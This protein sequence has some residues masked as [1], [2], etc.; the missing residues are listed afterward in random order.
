M[1][2]RS[3]LTEWYAFEDGLRR[4]AQNTR[5]HQRRFTEQLGT[6]FMRLIREQIQLQNIT[7]TGTYENSLVLEKT[8]IG[9]MTATVLTFRPVGP[10]ANR[11]AIYWKALEGGTLPNPRVPKSRLQVW[12]TLRFGNARVGKWIAASIRKKGTLAHPILSHVFLFDGEWNPIGLTPF[13]ERIRDR[14]FEE[15][16]RAIG[17]EIMGGGVMER[18]MITRGALAG[19]TRTLRRGVGGRFV[20]PR[21]FFPLN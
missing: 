18:H 5:E 15:V 12:S 19:R 14:L 1:V 8:Q 4:A 17:R 13:A 10:E 9:G 20:S 3:D 16:G 6:E 7:V 2:F 21:G 11:L